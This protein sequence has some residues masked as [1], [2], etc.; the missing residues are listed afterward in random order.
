LGMVFRVGG[1]LPTAALDG[2]LYKNRIIYWF[3]K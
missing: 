2:I 1:R 3:L